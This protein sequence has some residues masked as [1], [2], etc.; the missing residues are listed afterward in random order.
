MSTRAVLFCGKD[1]IF[2]GVFAGLAEKR[3]IMTGRETLT[4]GTVQGDGRMLS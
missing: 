4:A 3:L 2:S 1:D